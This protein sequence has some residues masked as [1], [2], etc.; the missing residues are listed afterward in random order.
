MKPQYIGRLRESLQIRILIV[1]SPKSLQ[2]SMRADI[3]S[4]LIHQ[5]ISTNSQIIKVSIAHS[6]TCKNRMEEGGGGSRE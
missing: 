2:T 4:N 5:W 3:E 6:F 1:L